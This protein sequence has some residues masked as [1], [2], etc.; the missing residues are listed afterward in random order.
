MYVGPTTTLGRVCQHGRVQAPGG[1]QGEVAPGFGP[2]ADAFAEVLAQQDASGGT[3]AAVAVWHDGAWVSDLWGGSADAARTRPWQ[4][5][6]LVMPYSVTKPLAALGALVLA[7][8][9]VLDL[10]EPL[11]SYWPELTART[12]LRQVLSHQS[13]VSVLESPAPSE[14]FY[15]WQ[16]MCA[17]VAAQPPS[18]P[19]GTAAGES[20]LLFGHLVGEVV[21]RVDG[22]TLGTFLREEVCGPEDLDFHVGLGDDE[23]RR[24][25][26]L[27]GFA[28]DFRRAQ[29]DASPV[30]QQ[31]LAN[32]P[33][34][35][36]PAVVNGERWRR[37]EVPAV[38][39]HGSARGVAGMYVAL[40]G[41]RILS[42]AMRREMTTV[43]ASG[44]DQ[45]LGRPARWGLGVGIEDDG[46]GMG[47]VGGSVGWWSSE[48]GYALGFTTGWIGDFE[49]GTSVENAL[50]GC[51]GLSE[52]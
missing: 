43:T 32:P 2:V 44:V 4:R 34:A 45:V 37:A 35:L 18:W 47:G 50:R 13:G 29:R 36:D 38:N 30:M 21:R 11:A 15:D 28:D 14:A 24:T 41:G 9:G 3:G 16:L 27:T 33:G 46:Y 26:D 5:D 1:W 48:G 7:D 42:P 31:A 19:P 49:R 51:L 17:L 8:R 23:L 12:S 52:L 22:R 25:A 40:E 6:T 20:A 39:G 10:D